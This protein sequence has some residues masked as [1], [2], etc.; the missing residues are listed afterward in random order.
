MT[1]PEMRSPKLSVGI[2]KKLAVMHSIQVI[3]FLAVN[4]RKELMTRRPVS[5]VF[6][7][8]WKLS[9]R[10]VFPPTG[11]HSSHERTHEGGA[12]RSAEG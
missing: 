8:G 10:S 5:A 6:M 1:A 12:C 2:A 9:R 7:P 11:F 3:Q 4:G